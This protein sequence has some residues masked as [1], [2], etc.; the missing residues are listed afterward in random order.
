MDGRLNSLRVS[1][2]PTPF[3]CRSSCE[4]TGERECQQQQGVPVIGSLGV[5]TVHS[6]RMSQCGTEIQATHST[7][8]QHTHANKP[9][10]VSAATQLKV[11][12]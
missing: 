4:P 8:S 10:V 9:S 5:A 2:G 7:V 11:Q 1:L 12:Q 3:E 6:P